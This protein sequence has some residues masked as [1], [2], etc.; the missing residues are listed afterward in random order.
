MLV[1]ERGLRFSSAVAST[2]PASKPWFSAFLTLRPFY[3][4]PCGSDSP[5]TTKF[6]LFLLHNCNESSRK[7]LCFLVVSGNTCERVVCFPQGVTTR[8]LGISVLGGWRHHSCQFSLHGNRCKR[9]RHRGGGHSLGDS[10]VVSCEGYCL[11]NRH[12]PAKGGACL[13]GPMN[14]LPYKQAFFLF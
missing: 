3:S 6:I 11:V 8:G 5:T 7:Y 2:V 14:R 1:G 4:S 9:K 10:R 13:Q 12:I